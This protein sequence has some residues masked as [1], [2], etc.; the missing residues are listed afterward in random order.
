MLSLV[1]SWPAINEK[2]VPQDYI[3]TFEKSG[4]AF[5]SVTKL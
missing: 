4:V 3:V 5:A 1:G 2:Y